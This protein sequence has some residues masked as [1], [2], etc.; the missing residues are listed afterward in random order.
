MLITPVIVKTTPANPNF[1]ILSLFIKYVIG[2][3]NKGLALAI[4]DMKVA[5]AVRAASV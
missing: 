1:E 3:A 5:P 2:R 4:N